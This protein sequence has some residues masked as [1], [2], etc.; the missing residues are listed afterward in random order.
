MATSFPST[1]Y[2]ARNFK[3]LKDAPDSVVEIVNQIRT[4][5]AQG[6]Y[7]QASDLLETNKTTL[8]RYLVDAEYVNKLNEEIRSVETYVKDN[9]TGLFYSEEEPDAMVGDIWIGGY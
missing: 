2:S 3:D 1:M 6:E 9:K 8:S 7:T 4:H 5:L